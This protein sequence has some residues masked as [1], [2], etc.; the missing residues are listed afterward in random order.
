M[1][2]ISHNSVNRQNVSALSTTRAAVSLLLLVL[3]ARYVTHQSRKLAALRFREWP[4]V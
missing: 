3:P 1:Q 4:F 2:W